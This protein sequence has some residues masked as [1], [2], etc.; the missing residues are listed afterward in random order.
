M[1]EGSRSRCQQL[2]APVPI[3]VP[4][5]PAMPEEETLGGRNGGDL[6][7]YVPQVTGIDCLTLLDYIKDNE[8][9]NEREKACG[10]EDD[11]G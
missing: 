8:T 2:S 3:S 5:F 9:C 1:G 4:D 11:I 10:N 7:V 6:M